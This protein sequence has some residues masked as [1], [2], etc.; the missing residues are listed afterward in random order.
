SPRAL[1]RALADDR[2][3]A[4]P[5]APRRTRALPRHPAV[6]AQLRGLPRTVRTDRSRR[7]A[8]MAPRKLPR[9]AR[10]APPPGERRREGW[11]VAALLRLRGR[12]RPRGAAPRHLGARGAVALHARANEGRPPWLLPEL[13]L[14]RR[15]PGRLHVDEPR[16]LRQARRQPLPP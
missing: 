5:R 10:H 14:R 9:L 6:A 11:P 2:S 3:D 12:Q 7:H 8:P 15:L 1:A 4:P 13:L 16:P